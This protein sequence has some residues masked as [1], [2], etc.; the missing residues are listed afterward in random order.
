MAIMTARNILII[1][2]FIFLLSGLGML[3]IGVFIKYQPTFS[4]LWL[5][6]KGNELFDINYLNNIL[7]VLISV[8]TL[9]FTLGIIGFFG[10]FFKNRLLISLYLTM[11][12]I[13]LVTKLI[14]IY[15]TIS[16]KGFFQVN[17]ELVLNETVSEGIHDK[18]NLAI[19]L[20]DDIQVLFKC[21]GSTGPTD[22]GNVSILTS[23]Y[24]YQNSSYLVFSNGCTKT[25]I[26]NINNRLPFIIN[27]LFIVFIV[28]LL[29]IMFSLY[30]CSKYN[31]K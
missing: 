10:A 20:I 8:G 25:I 2:N 31:K 18:N 4:E 16:F 27:I 12:V 28:E 14:I 29:A 24:P 9:T 23:C 1:F 7:L 21:C 5:S 11:M 3:L 30:L 13:L 17:L 22:Y 26:D 15:L 6:F 19:K